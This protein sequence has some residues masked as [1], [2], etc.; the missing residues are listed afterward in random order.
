MPQL[1]L[2]FLGMVVVFFFVSVT[3][4]YIK[5]EKILRNTY[6]YTEVKVKKFLEGG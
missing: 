3:I 5:I 6:I 4:H 2:F 1:L